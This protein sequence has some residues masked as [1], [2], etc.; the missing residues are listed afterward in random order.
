M[1]GKISMTNLPTLFAP[2]QEEI[3]QAVSKVI[4]AGIFVGGLEVSAFEQ[5]WSMFTRVNHTVGVGNGTDALAI[6]LRALGI[7][8]GDKV[9]TVSLSAVATATAIHLANAVPVWVDIAPSTL[10]MCPGSLQEVLHLHRQTPN[11]I[12]AIIPVHLYGHPADMHAIM[13]LARQYDCA[14]VEDCAQAHGAAIGTSLCGSFGDMAAFSFYPTKN[15]GC[16][17]DGGAI[18]S[19]DD[20]MASKAR[21]IAQY[22]WKERNFSVIPGQN[23]RLD[24][25][26]AAILRKRL[27]YLSTEN[28]RRRELA[29]QYRQRL[30]DLSQLVLPLECTGCTHVYHQFVI[31]TKQRNQ[32]MDFLALRTI[33]SQIHYPT[34]IHL[35]PAFQTLLSHRQVSLINTELACDTLVSIP[36]HPA[37]SNIEADQVSQAIHDFFQ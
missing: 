37:L 14:V 35:Q 1:S 10:T 34:P 8:A 36:V 21:I 22:G 19:N 12:K 23:S 17:G 20:S 32:L 15:L 3:K 6:C 16:I 11:P 2:Y 29:S 13:A 18:C 33:E 4:D 7:Q 24:T 31:R 25:L 27:P 30:N 26:Q 28:N 5:E 9:A